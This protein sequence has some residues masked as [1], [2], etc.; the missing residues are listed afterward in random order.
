MVELLKAFAV[1][2]KSCQ[3]NFELQGVFLLHAVAR[4]A[5]G[6]AKYKAR[7]PREWPKNKGGGALSGPWGPYKALKGLIR[8]LRAAFKTL[9]GI[10]SPLRAL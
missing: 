1:L 5:Q 6:G 10:I 4:G 7:S 3:S 9:R 8:S 2:T